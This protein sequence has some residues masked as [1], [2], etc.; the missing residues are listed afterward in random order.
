M[1]TKQLKKF[2]LLLLVDILFISALYLVSIL[3]FS[4]I[5]LLSGLDDAK[6]IAVTILLIVIVKIIFYIIFSNY[7]ILFS[8]IGLIDS[9]RLGLSVLASSL[10]LIIFFYFYNRDVTW[11]LF[12]YTAP[13]E[14]LLINLTRFSKRIYIRLI[15]V[16]SA[17]EKYINTIIIGASSAGKIAYDEILNNSKLHNKVILFLDDDPYKQNQSFV[18]LPVYGPI[19]DIEVFIEKF[20][21][22]EVIIAIANI[23][24]E[25]LNEIIEIVARNPVKIKRLPLL[26]ED[27]SEYRNML[28][29][30]IE[31]LL[32][33]RTIELD[34]LGLQNF[35]NGQK[36]FVSGAGG[37]IGSELCR[38]ILKNEPSLLIMFDIY[39]NTTYEVQLDLLSYIKDNNLNTKL[40]V[41]IGSVYNESRI[42]NIFKEYLP[43]LVFHA[44]AYK[45]VPLME[46]SAHEAVRTNVLGSYVVSKMADK[47]NVTKMIL[48]SSDKAVRPTNIMGATKTVAEHIIQYFSKNSQTSYS[49]VRFG[50]VLGSHGSVVP[51]FKKQIEQGGPVTITHP[52]INRFFMTIEEAVSLI[53][54]SAVYSSGGEI[55]ILD[56][57]EPVKIIELARKMI[58]LSGF[59]PDEE[60]A[61]KIIGLRPGEKLYEELL[62]DKTKN[63]RTA[64][65]K[66]FIEEKREI[67]DIDDFINLVEENI[68]KTNNEKMKE[69]VKELITSYQID[70]LNNKWG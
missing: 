33:R 20:S 51:L 48:V 11:V 1:S 46:S 67:K 16:I 59:T 58:R 40:E 52:E 55:F 41:L 30:R 57:G 13:I 56:M 61:I 64:N 35:I 10:V 47:Y 53:L 28:D 60:I 70:Y 12:L 36:V 2:A 14:I 45:H 25:R 69:L 9:F 62:V 42:E 3:I 5:L 54:Q 18:G 38:Q 37:S 34:N 66:I 43:N 29:V 32:N 65:D 4:N 49:A 44:A 8:H 17:N 6:T 7:K 27:S 21:I 50:N 23:S 26:L 19:K 63:I 68:D 15:G 24:K 39:E 31:D 22:K